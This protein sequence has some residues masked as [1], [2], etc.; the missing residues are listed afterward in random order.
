VS[1]SLDS[2][3]EVQLLLSSDFDFVVRVL[4]RVSE[5]VS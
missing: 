1:E 5:R 4:K 2:L 3:L